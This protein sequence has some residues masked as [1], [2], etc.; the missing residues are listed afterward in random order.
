MSRVRIPSGG[1]GATGYDAD[2]EHVVT[3]LK[4]VQN[5]LMR[6]WLAQLIDL[7]AQTCVMEPE[8]APEASRRS[9]TRQ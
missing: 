9:E 7:I 5:P 2:I 8:A 3:A 6:Y 4:Q 1:V